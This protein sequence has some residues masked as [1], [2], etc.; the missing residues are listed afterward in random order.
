[1][2]QLLKY[3]FLC[4]NQTQLWL[5]ISYQSQYSFMLKKITNYLKK[6]FILP[7]LK[8]MIMVSGA[9]FL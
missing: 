4:I 5:D 2:I 7:T 3:N 1:M 6:K 9:N 8:G